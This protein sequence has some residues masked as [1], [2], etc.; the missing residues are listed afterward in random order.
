LHRR[1]ILVAGSIPGR[2]DREQRL[3]IFASGAADPATEPPPVRAAPAETVSDGFKASAQ[4]A[5]VTSNAQVRAH[6]YKFWSAATVS[7]L[8]LK[9]SGQLFP[10]VANRKQIS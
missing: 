5:N 4:C 8:G 10:V 7:L 6:S 3:R 2:S 9:I 1:W